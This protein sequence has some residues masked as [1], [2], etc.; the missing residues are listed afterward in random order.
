MPL[1]MESKKVRAFTVFEFDNRETNLKR[2]FQAQ[3]ELMKDRAMVILETGRKTIDNNASYYVVTRDS[4]NNIPVNQLF[5]FT[6]YLAKRYT[7][8]I[9][10]TATDNPTAELCKSMWLVDKIEFERD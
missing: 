7:V 3:L 9:A 10:I 1:A 5:L 6:D 8:H 2:Y 4:S